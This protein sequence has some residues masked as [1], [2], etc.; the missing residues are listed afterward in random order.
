[1][2]F[3]S[4]ERILW[5]LQPIREHYGVRSHILSGFRCFPTI[6]GEIR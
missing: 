2:L 5:K 1:M 3:L 6:K 4:G